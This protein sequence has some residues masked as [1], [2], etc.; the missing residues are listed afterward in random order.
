MDAKTIKIK[1]E[2]PFGIVIKSEARKYIQYAFNGAEKVLIVADETVFRLF[3][4][5]LKKLVKN[6]GAEAYTFIYPTGESAKNKHVLDKL[7]ILM[8]ELNIKKTDCLLAF[9][10][11]SSAQLAGFA[12][13]IFKSGVPYVYLPTTLMGMINPMTDG[14]VGVDFLGK[15]DL[16][17]NK[18]Y[19]VAVFIDPDY[20]KTLPALCVQD[21][22][23]EIIRRMMIGNKKLIQRMEVEDL[24]VEEL[25]SASISVGEKM[26]SNRLFS[27]K[28]KSKYAI[29]F[30][31]AAE[32][33]IGLGVPYG[34]LI[35]CGIMATIDSAM[36]L[37]ISS[38]IDERMVKLFEKYQ[39]KWDIGIALSK[40]W[41][42]ILETDKKKISLVLP[43]GMGK[44]RVCK[45]T[46]EKIKERF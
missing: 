30:S 3:G 26:K 36:T 41:Q 28:K 21:G 44:L 23:A 17:S 16:L 1:C 8:T 18:Y 5:G 20:L 19:P 22:Y 31:S 25:I 13:F 38:A 39:I 9:G 37:G 34:K 24:P 46:K 43:S 33:I 45:L 40:L 7:L 2:K 14:K 32:K 11:R 10:G 29:P 42:T 12:S 6:A 15:K 4:N 27:L 35:A